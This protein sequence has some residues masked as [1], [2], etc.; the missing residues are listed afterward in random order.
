MR[1]VISLAVGLM[2]AGSAYADVVFNNPFDAT[3][4]NGNC[5]FSSTCASEIGKVDDFAAQLFTLDTGVTLT[6]GSFT[7]L[8]GLDL[9]GPGD[10]NWAFYTDAGVVPGT[11]LFSGTAGISGSSSAGEDVNGLYIDTYTFDI[12]SV[13]LASGSYFFALQTISEFYTND[14]AQGITDSGAAETN[15]GGA[16]WAAEYEFIGGVAVG[17]NGDLT[18]PE[19]A[20]LG[21]VGVG[22]GVLGLMRRRKAR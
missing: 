19:P 6:S 12:P 10:V 18:T 17:L 15:D 4:D 14:L 5:A 16:T 9:G 20:T 8:D 1:R 21:F 11:L 13:V 3:A 22:F 2:A 7:E